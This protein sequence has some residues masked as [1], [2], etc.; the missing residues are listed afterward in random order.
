M[1]ATATAP[2]VLL[3]NDRY[4]PDW[5]VTVDG[6]PEKV[7]RCNYLMRGVQVPAGEH[8]IE[9]RFQPPITGLYISLAAIFVALGLV[10]LLAV[11]KPPADD[12]APG[13][14]SP[15]VA[16]SA[17]AAAEKTRARSPVVS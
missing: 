15:S 8:K 16:N 1:R 6:K 11:V 12:P 2:A 17:G 13:A 7:L 5:R 9:F 14:P 3:L 4:A 10:G